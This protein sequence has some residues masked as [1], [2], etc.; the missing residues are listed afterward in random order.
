MDFRTAFRLLIF[1][2][3]FGSVAI[4]TAS[5]SEG[6]RGF[7]SLLA[8]IFL[9]WVLT[10]FFH[11]PSTLKEWK[12]TG[13]PWEPRTPEQQVIWEQKIKRKEPYR[14]AYVL[15]GLLV[16]G[17]LRNH[18]RELL[19]LVPPFFAGGLATWS[20][21]YSWFIYRKRGKLGRM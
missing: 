12:K 11:I 1:P 19:P 7:Y 10:E 15:V 17:I 20:L 18:F 6:I 2:I 21:R 9:G 8:G 3:I 16:A 5:L 14:Y 4:W 13:K